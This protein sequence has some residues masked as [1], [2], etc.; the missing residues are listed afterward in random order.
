MAVV[1]CS[2]RGGATFLPSGATP[3]LRSTRGMGERQRA[4]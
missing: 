3:D 2:A 1:P 4:S